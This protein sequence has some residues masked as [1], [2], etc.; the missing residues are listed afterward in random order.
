MSMA[1]QEDRRRCICTAGLTLPAHFSVLTFFREQESKICAKETSG[2]GNLRF[3]N[4]KA[5]LSRASE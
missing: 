1:R 2:K 3:L 5:K 4:I